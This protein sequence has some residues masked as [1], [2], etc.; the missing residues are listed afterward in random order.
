MIDGL[1][2]RRRYKFLGNFWVGVFGVGG[3]GGLALEGWTAEDNMLAFVFVVLG[4][5]STHTN[6]CVLV[7]TDTVFFSVLSFCVCDCLLA[8]V[9][10]FFAT[11]SRSASVASLLSLPPFLSL[12]SS[13]SLS[14]SLPSLSASLVS[15]FLSL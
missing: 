3:A 11:I 2:V 9:C 8:C 15:L 1:E 14:L 13:S 5:A 7:V 6:C 12:S 10:L 4:A